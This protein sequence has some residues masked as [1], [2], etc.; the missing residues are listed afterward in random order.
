MFVSSQW[1]FPT[2]DTPGF[3]DLF[4]KE[5]LNFI[6]RVTYLFIFYSRSR[7]HLLCIFWMS[8]ELMTPSWNSCLPPQQ[9]L[10]CYLLKNWTAGTSFLNTE[11]KHTLAFLFSRQSLS[12]FCLLGLTCPQTGFKCQT[13]LSPVLIPSLW[14]M[15]LVP[16]TLNLGSSHHLGDG[17][18]KERTGYKF[19]TL[20][21]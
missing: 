10:D 4:Y 15:W 1:I 16:V 13:N 14:K 8:F 20:E 12:V 19:I 17:Q 2:Y 21:N 3:V 5:L 9:T 6:P 11:V 18:W 7:C